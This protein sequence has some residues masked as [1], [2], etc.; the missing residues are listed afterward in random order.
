MTN[1][2]FTSDDDTFIRAQ[3][4]VRLL[5]LPAEQERRV[6]EILEAFEGWDVAQEREACAQIA[7]DG[8]FHPDKII[9]L[10]DH[11]MKIAAAIRAR[12]TPKKQ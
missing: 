7:E 5:G 9:D 8:F 3:K 11:G 1:E 12:A 4:M 10:V 2:V 6:F